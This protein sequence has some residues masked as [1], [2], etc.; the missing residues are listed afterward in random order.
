MGGDTMSHLDRALGLY[1]EET[2]IKKL[3]IDYT[4]SDDKQEKQALRIAI[5]TLKQENKG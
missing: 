3:E 5:I 4:L 2:R 1:R